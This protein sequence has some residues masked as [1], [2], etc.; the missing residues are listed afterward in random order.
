MLDYDRIIVSK[1]TVAELIP[2]D[3]RKSLLSLEEEPQKSAS[4]Y[5]YLF[6]LGALETALNLQKHVPTDIAENLNISYRPDD[7][8]GYLDVFYPETTNTALPTIVW[9]HGGGWIS[10]T[11]DQVANYLRIL[12]S[13]GYTVVGVDYSIAPENKYP[14][15]LIQVNDALN[16]LIKPENAERLHIDTNKLALAGDS[17]GSQIA[18][19]IATIIT[20]EGYR[21]TLND[22]ISQAAPS[23]SNILPELKADQL[24]GVVLTCGA[25]NLETLISPPINYPDDSKEIQEFLPTAMCSYSG[26]VDF[27]NDELFQTVSVFNYVDG[28]FPPSFLTA[29]DK[30][31][32]EDESRRLDEKLKELGVRTDVLFY[33]EVIGLDHEYQFDL[34]DAGGYGKKALERIIAF[35]QNIFA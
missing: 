25:Y 35:L 27:L 21:N 14:L 15:P 34:D 2:E 26:K 9:V 16:Y 4:H 31:F 33:E 28:N 7:K 1:S 24:K 13:Y 10:G 32:L 30:D 20:N 11:K 22:L 6:D 23:V 17:A 29:G 5:R 8:D 3:I 18:A 19:Q 12:A